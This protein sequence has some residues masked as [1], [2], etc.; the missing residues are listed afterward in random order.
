MQKTKSIEKTKE[1]KNQNIMLAVFWSCFETR[2]I[3]GQN[4]LSEMAKYI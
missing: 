2:R 4:I 3:R 1:M